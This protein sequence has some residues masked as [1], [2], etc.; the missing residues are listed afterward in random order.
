MTAQPSPNAIWRATF[1]AALALIAALAVLHWR[2]LGGPA[3]PLDDAYIVLFNARALL[4]NAPNFPNELPLTGA[5]SL[6]HTLL[7]A[8]FAAMF[9]PE[10]SLWALCWLGVAAAATG[11]LAL[12]RAVGL[13]VV[14]SAA[15]M[16]AALTMG[17][18]PIVLLNGL[19]TSWA[20]AALLWIFVCFAR[21]PA[22]RI[23]AFLCGL[24]PFIRPELGLFSVMLLLGAAAE[25][26]SRPRDALLAAALCIG[27]ALALLCVQWALSGAPL[28]RTGEAKRLFFGEAVK[29]VALRIAIFMRNL[30]EFL[31]SMGLLWVGAIV[32]RGAGPR[33]AYAAAVLLTLAAAIW[34]GS[35]PAQNAYRF[36]WYLMPPM[37]FALAVAA[38]GAGWRAGLARAAI[39]ASL[40][41]NLWGQARSG[42]FDLSMAADARVVH[43]AQGAWVRG[44]LDPM[45]MLAVHDVGFVSWGTDQRLVDI[46]G[47]KTPG[48]IAVHARLTGQ[49]GLDAMPQALDEI[50]RGAEACAM[51][52]LDDW[53]DKV[54]FASGLEA[55]GWTV[56]RL[57]GTDMPVY[58]AFRVTP[59]EGPLPGCI[60]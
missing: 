41:L 22:S 5:T 47:L 17:R 53:N 58:V 49:Q 21:D 43:Q 26:K 32:V 34:Y 11:A 52:V 57:S 3:F 55:R 6:L 10:T 36:M 28:P 31:P 7:V 60:D 15:L 1:A 37:V 14:W 35:I 59:P 46:V 13:S 23:G 27:P 42:A 8:P 44:N 18:A 40:A 33:K 48:S 51:L 29:P 2:A 16:I 54:H 9:D 20:M 19:E 38:A 50:L 45:R 39:A 30:G 25:L 4:E 24:L 12:G 56:Q